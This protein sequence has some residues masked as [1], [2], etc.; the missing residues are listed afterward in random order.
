[1]ASKDQGNLDSLVHENI[2]RTF[3]Y[4]R[5]RFFWLKFLPKYTFAPSL[6][7]DIFRV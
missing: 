5:Y 7:I 4:E 6:E 1:M 3:K 2:L